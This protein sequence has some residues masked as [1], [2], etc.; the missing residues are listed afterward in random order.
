MF[1][2]FDGLAGGALVDERFAREFDDHGR[3]VSDSGARGKGAIR[4]VKK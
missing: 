1:L 3:V 4:L 2:A